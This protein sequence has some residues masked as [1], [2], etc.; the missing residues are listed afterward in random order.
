MK[1]ILSGDLNTAQEVQGQGPRSQRGMRHETLGK[2]PAPGSL[3][4]IPS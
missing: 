4:Y 3:S 2:C 1:R